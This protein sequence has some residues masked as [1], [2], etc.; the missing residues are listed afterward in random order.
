MAS[1]NVR[2]DSMSI[3]DETLNVIDAAIAERS[4]LKHPFYQAWQAGTLS[5]EALIDYTQQYYHH[6]A[7]FPMYLS[8]LHSH[9]EDTTTR[10]M[11]LENLIDEERGEDNHP[12][13]WLRF[14]A[15]IGSSREAVLVSE[16]RKETQATV[17]TFRRLTASGSVGEG[18]AALY[19]YE[20]Q[21]PMVSQTK[22]QGL[23]QWYGVSDKE[24]VAYF[25]VHAEAD[26]VHASS[27][28]T[29]LAR[30]IESEVDANRAVSAAREAADAAWKLLSDVCVNNNIDMSVAG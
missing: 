6:V 17:N 11:L 4:L 9:T 12:E 8:G 5:R 29:E 26:V 27:E 28:R 19:A 23:K 30:Y 24:T 2:I 20:S 1:P 21:I 25:D 16:P 14:A 10:K 15:G 3:A 13:L 18:L 7:A 22:A